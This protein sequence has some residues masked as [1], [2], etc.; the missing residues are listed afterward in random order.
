MARAVIGSSLGLAW[1]DNTNNEDG[2]KIER[3]TGSACTVFAQIAT[4]GLNVTTYTN[5][6]L[7]RGTTYRYRVRAYNASG[8]SDY[9]NIAV[10]TTPR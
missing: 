8:N 5:T 3:C 7:R 2:F 10:A 1:T 6:G 4:V 9:S